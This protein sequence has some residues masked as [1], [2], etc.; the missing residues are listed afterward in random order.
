MLSHNWQAVVIFSVALYSLVYA[1]PTQN[2]TG[3]YPLAVRLPY[4]TYA[5]YYNS[6][7]D[8]NIWLGIRYAAAPIGQNR[9]KAAQP[10]AKN[11]T[12]TIQANAL[13]NQCPQATVSLV[14]SHTLSLSHFIRLSQQIR[15]QGTTRTVYSLTFIHQITP[16]ISLSS[17]G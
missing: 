3:P 7:A 13:P 16:R 9:W 8:L 12:A 5:G 6:S 14:R 10:P 11:F 2:P 1:A 17:F 15:R 4:G